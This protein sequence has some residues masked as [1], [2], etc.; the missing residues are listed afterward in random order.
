M[1]QG[2]IE[3]KEKNQ[4]VVLLFRIS[5]GDENQPADRALGDSSFVDI[6]IAIS[7]LHN[8]AWSSKYLG[9]FCRFCL[10]GD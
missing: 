4:L 7:Q 1:S 9:H 2:V 8:L 10:S 6:S 5:K 3:V